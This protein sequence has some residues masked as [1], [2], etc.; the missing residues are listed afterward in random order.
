[1]SPAYIATQVTGGSGNG[2]GKT[3]AVRTS[4]RVASATATAVK[5]AASAAAVSTPAHDASDAESA[6]DNVDASGNGTH[7]MHHPADS[8]RMQV[9][10]ITYHQCFNHFYCTLRWSSSAMIEL[11]QYICIL[12][13]GHVPTL[14]SSAL[15]RVQQFKAA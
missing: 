10:T 4:G 9:H 13:E 8:S 12:L 14:T 11:L 5:A 7:G 2:K 15:H 1:V 6:D 3:S